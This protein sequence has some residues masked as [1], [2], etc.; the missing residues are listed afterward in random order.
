[1]RHSET[2]APGLFQV[3]TL[4]KLASAAAFERGGRLVD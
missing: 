3:G 2:A 4:A 1:M